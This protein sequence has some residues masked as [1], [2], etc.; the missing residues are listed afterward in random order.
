MQLEK[1]QA[2]SDGSLMMHVEKGP[3]GNLASSVVVEYNLC[4]YLE[5]NS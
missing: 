1:K 5:N 3:T 4:S 2:Q